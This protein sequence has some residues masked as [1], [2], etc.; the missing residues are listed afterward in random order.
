MWA[1]ASLFGGIQCPI[2]KD[3]LLFRKFGIFVLICLWL[4]F[5]RAESLDVW[6]AN[7]LSRIKPDARFVESFSNRKDKIIKIEGARN[8]YEPFQFVISTQ[9]EAISGVRIEMT[10]LVNHNPPSADTIPAESIK[11]YL[12]HYIYIAKSTPRSSLAFGWYPDA[13]IPWAAVENFI[14]PP[15]SNQPFL[16]EVHIPSN[17]RAGLYLGQLKINALGKT[18]VVINFEL[19]VWNFTLPSPSLQTSFGLSYE[20]LIN[21]HHLQPGTP[22]YWS[23]IKKYNESLIE[24]RL[25]PI[26][27]LTP[28]ALSD[29]SFDTTNLTPLLAYYFDSL[30]VNASMYAFNLNAPFADP[31]GEDWT[32]TQRYLESYY[33]YLLKHNWAEHHYAYLID[34]PSDSIAYQKVR[35]IGA[36]LHQINPKIKLLCT[37]QIKPENPNW[38]DFYGYVDIYCPLFFLYDSAHAHWRQGLG[39]EVWVYTACTQGPNPTPWWQIDM[40]LM[41]YRIVPWQIR[42]YDISGLL[43]WSTN[44]WQESP[45][46]WVKPAGFS[47]QRGDFWNG[48]GSL[49]YP[50]TKVGIDG[51]ITSLRLKQLR[52]GIEDYEYLSLLFRMGEADF[53]RSQICQLTTSFYNWQT[54][55]EIL[56]EVRKTIGERI[57]AINSISEDDKS[58]LKS[59]NPQIAIN[60]NPFRKLTK[61]K[62]LMPN[63]RSNQ[64]KIFSLN[65]SL[66]RCLKLSESKDGLFI[67]IWDGKD[68]EGSCVAPGVYLIKSDGTKSGSKKLVLI[69]D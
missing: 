38:G 48:E 10:P 9:D 14:I 49:F 60:P 54:D 45:D 2:V 11:F 42:Y 64:L 19:N 21:Y 16:G 40:P 32:K 33:Q 5:C 65:G 66:I 55:P 13:L 69:K 15:Q 7:P 4:G 30:K 61:I 29:G 68:E 18:P 36:M 23:I 24:H 58:A 41:N 3:K 62:W 34:E 52:E 51:P 59:E 37:E 1:T 6:V 22:E 28:R 43:Y 35:Q 17:I 8:E 67:G 46:P 47:N 27:L 50:G 31:F 39:D 56:F 44:Y 57:S 63:Y 25:M 53:A 12:E 26:C 20:N